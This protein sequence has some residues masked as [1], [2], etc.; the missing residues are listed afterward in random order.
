MAQ[1]FLVRI[2]RNGESLISIAFLV[3]ELFNPDTQTKMPRPVPRPN[4][5]DLKFSGE[6]LT[7][8]CSSWPKNRKHRGL[9]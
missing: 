8:I 9:G 3:V 7:P 5:Q 6:T 2:L 4:F 1:L